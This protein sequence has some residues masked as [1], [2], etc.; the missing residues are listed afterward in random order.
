MDDTTRELVA[1]ARLVRNYG[2]RSG[3][4]ID[5]RLIEALRPFDAPNAAP[6]GEDHVA[7]QRA[8]RDSIAQ[9]RP[10]TLSE[11]VNGFDPFQP[12]PREARL[13]QRVRRFLSTP[14]NYVIVLG[15]ALVLLTYHFSIWLKQAEHF[16]AEFVELREVRPQALMAEIRALK[17]QID[18]NTD[19]LVV[20][21]NLAGAVSD[22][23]LAEDLTSILV[24]KAVQLRRF[25]E[26]QAALIGQGAV[27]EYQFHPFS[28]FGGQLAA[29]GQ[30]VGGLFR[31][32]PEQEKI[33]QLASSDFVCPI[34]TYSVDSIIPPE[35]MGPADRV[36]YRAMLEETEEVQK[37]IC[38]IGV[39][40]VVSR[41]ALAD[42]AA[43]VGQRREIR[44]DSSL[45]LRAHRIGELVDIASNWWLPA[46]YG[47]LGAVIF[48]LRRYLNPLV[49]DPTTIR[50]LLRL[51]F[52]AFAGISIAWF[53][54]PTT[55]SDLSF[56][57]ISIGAL[58]LAFLLGYSLDAFFGL[59]DKL[60]ALLGSTVERL[61]SG[62]R[63]PQT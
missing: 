29:L 46:I 49:P 25:H 47:A 24:E 58:A 18:A 3:L 6:T 42:G 28:A 33:K 19:D 30:R 12:H 51:L 7:L 39:G 35:A 21:A 26:R 17:S 59:L 44:F 61:G 50:S 20:D 37:I 41:A 52:G 43:S 38:M 15:V 22:G 10:T 53:W 8:V 4:L 55:L 57:G 36:A 31:D 32:A 63:Q 13:H 48:S 23:A 27:I 45:E 56:S 1:H 2:V 5:D 34:E 11:L 60:V 62:E 14:I 16:S 9:I 40:N 54:A